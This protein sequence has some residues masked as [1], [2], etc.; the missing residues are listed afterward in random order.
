MFKAVCF[1]VSLFVSVSYGQIN[2]KTDFEGAS[3]K[4]IKIQGNSV[5]FKPGGIGDR[6]FTCWWYLKLENVN[7]AE[8]LT[9]TVDAKGLKQSRNRGIGSFWALPDVMTYSYDGSDWKQSDKGKKTKNS[10][11]WKITP[12]SKTVWVAW[13]PPYVPGDSKKLAERLSSEHC[14]PFILCQTRG[15]RPVQAMKIT[16][17]DNKPKKA[18]WIQ[19]RQHAWES[20]SSWVGEGLAEWLCS[21]SS[22][23]KELRSKAVIYFVPIMDVDNVATGN[24]GKEQFPHDH[25]RDWSEKPHWSSVASAQKIMKGHIDDGSMTLFIDLHNPGPTSKETFLFA[26]DEDILTKSNLKAQQKFIKALKDHV[27]G[28]LPFKGLVKVSGKNYHPLWKAISKSWFVMNSEES[29]CGVTIEVP[30]NAKNSH[31][32]GYKQTGKEIAQSLLSYLK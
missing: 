24:G 15:G 25:N 6:G 19:A 10:G 26:A 11:T 5:S 23:A 32:E 22:E 16:S 20:G 4:D 3:A 9:I 17:I 28:P 8:E 18:I 31:P 30:W 29:S 7:T 1:C 13:G 12:K 21:S 14:K 27:K 2:V